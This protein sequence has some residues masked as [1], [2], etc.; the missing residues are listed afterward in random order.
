MD[1]ERP[2]LARKKKVRRIQLGAVGVVLLALVT[3]GISQ[4]KPAAPTVEASTVWMDTVKR[5]PMLRSVRGTGT[6]VPEVIRWIPAATDGRVERLVLD[7]GA[8]V[9]AQSILLEM[10]DPNQVQRTLTAGFEL[11]GAEAEYLNLEA[12]L[13]SERLTQE[14][15]AARLKAEYEQAR[16]R[17]DADEELARQQ[18]LPE[19]TRKV[20]QG[21]ANELANR[22]A[23]EQRRVATTTRSANAQLAAARANLEQL[24]AM[25]RLQQSQLASLQVRAG[26]NGVLQQ[27]SVEVGQSVVPGTILAKVVDPTRLKAQIRVAET[28]A[29]D[30]QRG[31]AATIDTRNGVVK[32]RVIRVDPA[33]QNGTVAVDVAFDEPLPRGARPDLTVDGTIELERLNDVLFVSR[34][35]SAQELSA[36]SHFRLNEKGDEAV[37]VKVNFGRGSVSAIEIQSGLKE[38]DRVILSDMSAWDEADR[39]RLN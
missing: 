21:T 32:G 39:I 9:E 25:A 4:I 5:G 26:I 14:A 18:L 38:G 23:I 29:R 27:I 10:S 22:Y 30:I 7:P 16:L 36:G 2:D 24:R 37:R 31:Q 35:V 33:A 15:N 34:P 28:Q 6:L 8:A 1:I 19:I 13:E 3:L 12:R 17:A 20:S 11:R